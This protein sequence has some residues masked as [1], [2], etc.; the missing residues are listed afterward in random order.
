MKTLLFVDDEPRVLQALQR[1]LYDMRHE[2]RVHFVNECAKALD[3]MAATPVDV[4]ITDMTM[5]F[6]DGAQLL[7]EVMQRHPNTVRLVLSGH[8]DRESILR[9]VG[10][11]H[12]Y[13]SK[14]CNPLELRG[15]IGRALALRDLLGNE[16]LKQ[17]ATGTR[18]LP[19]LPALHVQLTRELSKEEPSMERIGE[20]ITKDVGLTTKILQVVNSAFFGLPQTITR[21]ADAVLYL[22]LAT[23][24]ALVLSAH[25]FSQFD[26]KKVKGFSIRALEEHSWL[27][28][29]LARRIA[30]AEHCDPKIDDQCFLAGLLH[31][32]GRLILANGMPE[33]YALVLEKARQRAEPLWEVERAE[34]GASQAEVG[35]YLLGLW[36][37]PNPVVEGVALHHRPAD[38]AGRGFSPVIAVH[39]A[40]AFAHDQA[41]DHPYWPG[42]EIDFATLAQLGLAG[43]LEA[44][45]EK[46]L[47]GAT[48]HGAPLTV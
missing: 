10:P 17:V 28:A 21:P 38:C 24:R 19:T 23:M 13:L 35:G 18:S 15:A 48:E 5:P 39:V 47:A 12:Q 40:N 1:Q 44:W 9:L 32:V 26:E 45:K 22:G 33:Q 3:F 42:D 4:I 7:T 2:W 11:A 37:L 34:L 14:P 43:R 30:D 8:A 6:M 41:G 27:T 25:I 46:C 36:A 20:I 16:K 31:E 29:T